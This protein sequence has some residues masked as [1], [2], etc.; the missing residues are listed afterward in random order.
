M[1]IFKKFLVNFLLHPL[2]SNRDK[3][4][5]A[6][7]QDLIYVSGLAIVLNVILTTIATIIIISSTIMHPVRVHLAD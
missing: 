7:D 4:G 3:S 1:C 6:K 5:K 2:W